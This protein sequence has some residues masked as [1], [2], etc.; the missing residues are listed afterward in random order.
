M[1]CAARALAQHIERNP[2]SM[3][4]GCE[5]TDL[6]LHLGLHAE[7]VFRKRRQSDFHAFRFYLDSDC[8]PDERAQTRAPGQTEQLFNGTSE[9]M[10][11]FMKDC[12]DHAIFDGV[13]CALTCACACALVSNDCARRAARPASLTAEVYDLLRSEQ[14][15]ACRVSRSGT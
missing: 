2:V 4:S 9:I 13:V 3:R 14:L 12:H 8:T 7:L 10:M 1:E 11:S 5:S 6:H 15:R